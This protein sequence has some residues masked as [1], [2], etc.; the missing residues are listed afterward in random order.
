LYRPL[1]YNHASLRESELEF[2][3]D[4]DPVVATSGIDGF[5]RRASSTAPA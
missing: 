3:V 5:K 1:R 4:R 2:V